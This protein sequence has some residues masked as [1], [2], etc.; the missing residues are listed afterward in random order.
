MIRYS[1]FVLL[2]VLACCGCVLVPPQSSSSACTPDKNQRLLDLLNAGE[3]RP[4]DNVMVCGVTIGASRTHFGGPEGSH[5][6]LPLRVA[7][8]DGSSR[9]VEV[10]TNDDLDGT[11]SAPEGA[12]VSAY[13]QAFFDR[14]GRFAAGIHDVH[15]S[16]HRGADDGWVIINGQRFPKHC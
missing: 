5:Q 7:F 2:A 10:V 4:V 3:S 16:T 8:P 11:L 9:L 15:C 1:L 14:T 13:G 12:A 6:I